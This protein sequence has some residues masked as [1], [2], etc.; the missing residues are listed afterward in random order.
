[1][2]QSND[3]DLEGGPNVVSLRQAQRNFLEFGAC[4][5]RCKDVVRK[6]TPE[7]ERDPEWKPD[8]IT[9]EQVMPLLLDVYPSLGEPWAEHLNDIWDRT[10]DSI[11]YTDFAFLSWHLV[12][13]LKLNNTECFTEVFALVETLLAHGDKFVQDAVVVGLLEDIQIIALGEGV[14]LSQFHKFLGFR[15]RKAWTQLI[16]FWNGSGKK[17]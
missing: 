9:R 11:L 4:E 6:P 3:P 12:G 16:D 15:A 10:S 13:S 8:L 5:E 17:D 1:M 14:E 2:C 7:D